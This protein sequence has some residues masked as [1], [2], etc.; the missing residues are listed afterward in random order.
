MKNDDDVTIDQLIAYARRRR[1]H[2]E[3]GGLIEELAEV[4]EGRHRALIRIRE[5]I[6]SH[7]KDYDHD[8]RCERSQIDE[9]DALSRADLEALITPPC[10][11]RCQLSIVARILEAIPPE[12]IR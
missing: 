5:M 11:P 8:D 3:V 6:L 4:L 7:G 1:K 9:Y 2:P 10:D 12:K